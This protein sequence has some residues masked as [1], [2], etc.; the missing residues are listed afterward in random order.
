MYSSPFLIRTA[1]PALIN[2]PRN[3]P[4]WRIISVTR[5]T[6][7]HSGYARRTGRLIGAPN[8]ATVS[9]ERCR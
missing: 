3:R 1:H 4:G 8:R 6:P 9:F 7:Y 2:A 5:L